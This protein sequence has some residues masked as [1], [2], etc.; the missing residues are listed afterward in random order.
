MTVMLVLLKHNTWRGLHDGQID[1]N[2]DCKGG[3]HDG[4]D[5]H[6]DEDIHSH[7]LTPCPMDPLMLLMMVMVMVMM[8]I[9]TMIMM[10]MMR[11]RITILS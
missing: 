11:R 8:M 4:H 10:T 9:V 7:H 6:V 5:G 3:P 1:A 2:D